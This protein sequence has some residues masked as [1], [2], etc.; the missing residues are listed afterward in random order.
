MSFCVIVAY[1]K[2]QVDKATIGFTLANAALDLREKVSVALAGEGVWL[3]FKGYAD[4]LDNGSPFKPL[5]ELIREFLDK[6]GVLNV[7]TP[8]MQKRGIK[9]TYVLDGARLISGSDLIRILK[10]AD[11]S[12][13]L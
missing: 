2:E 11:R 6:G 4:E 10:E 7:C 12:I 3:A 1:G 13:Q 9:D 5:N 8:C